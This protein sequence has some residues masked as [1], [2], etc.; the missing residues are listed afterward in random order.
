[1]PWSKVLSFSDP[2]LYQSSIRAADVELYPTARGEFRAE[3]TQINLHQLW[4]QRFEEK[5]P[6]V[7]AGRIR[8]GR[9]VIG[10]LTAD[11]Q[12]E[13]QHCGVQFRRATS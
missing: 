13:L 8:P 10:F 1:M 3:L 6:Q 7:Y 4:M 12:P 5:L 2:F 11:R 9:R